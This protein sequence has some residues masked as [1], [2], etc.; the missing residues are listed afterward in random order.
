MTAQ[1]NISKR[2]VRVKNLNFSPEMHGD[3]K[4]ARVDLSLEVLLDHDD[5][6]QFVLENPNDLVDSGV[7]H[8]LWDEEGV[9]RLQVSNIKL[10]IKVM[11]FVRLGMVKAKK[12]VEFENAVL[13]S[14][15]LE[16]M[17]GHKAKL[18]CQVR[19]DPSANL[20]MLEEITIK[21]EAQFAY[22]GQAAKPEGDEAQAEMNV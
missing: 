8:E 1:I 18:R 16:F 6:G 2:Q 3:G 19:V 11:G 9:P 14:C 4:V 13:K 21:E 22:N 5:I 17:L 15:S 10:P 7:L 20:D 12:P